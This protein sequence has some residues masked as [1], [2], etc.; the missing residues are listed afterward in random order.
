[1]RDESARKK[2]ECASARQRV[3]SVVLHEVAVVNNPRLSGG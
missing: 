2:S 3:L 1:M